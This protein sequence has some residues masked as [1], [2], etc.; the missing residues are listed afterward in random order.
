MRSPGPVFDLR[1]ALTEEMRAAAEALAQSDG[2]KKGV[3]RCRVRIKR[4]RALARIGAASAPGLASVFNDSARTVMRILAEARDLAALSDAAQSIA[5]TA[6]KREAAA[7]ETISITLDAER[8]SVGPIDLAEAQGGLRDLLALAQVWP[9]TSARQLRRGA[10]RIVRRARRA[11]ERGRESSTPKRRHRWRK[12]EKD[13]YI[14]ALLLKDAW[15]T[16]R[17]RKLGKK[18]GKALGVERDAVLLLH[19]IHA[20]PEI[21]GPDKG[22]TRAQRAIER[23]RQKY[24]VRADRLGAKI[25]A[26]GA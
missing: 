21:A 14:A 20:A 11:R 5:E 16:P 9:E 25:R 12:R 2:R 26:R 17:Q 10:K 4:A 15:P 22:A 7:L 18:V 8:A 19:R 13:R 24:S 6:R 1:A 3:H 23:Q